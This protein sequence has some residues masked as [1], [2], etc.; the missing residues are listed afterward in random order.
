MTEPATE[1]QI[2]A[3]R[4]AVRRRAQRLDCLW[5]RVMSAP[6]MGGIL[7]TALLVAAA[8]AGGGW[9]G[10]AALF[11]ILLLAVVGSLALIT[12]LLFAT[13]VA[14]LPVFGIA[15]ARQRRQVRR[16]LTVL[17][18]WQRA[19]VLA[20]LSTDEF[21]YTRSLVAP[22]IE[23]FPAPHELSPVAAPDGEGNEM[24]A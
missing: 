1:D 18:P 10:P 14:M 21:D 24:A 17:P 22:L 5:F 9:R 4:E 6:M 12:M 11:L 13:A 23:E 20:P 16:E 7:L 2:A 3:L 8:I 19:A 15:L